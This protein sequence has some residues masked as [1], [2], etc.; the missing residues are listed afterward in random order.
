MDKRTVCEE[1]LSSPESVTHIARRTGLTR[2]V[3]I[4]GL[5]T[6]VTTLPQNLPLMT[7]NQ[8]P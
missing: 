3:Y 4:I 8:Q 6:N 1:A 5:W 7:L 2:G